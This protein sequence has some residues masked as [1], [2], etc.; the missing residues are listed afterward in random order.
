MKTIFKYNFTVKKQTNLLI[1]MNRI[2]IVLVLFCS[3]SMVGQE[4]PKQKIIPSMEVKI[5]FERDFPK[6]IPEWTKDFGGED[7]DQL[8]YNA[9]FKTSTSE[10]LAVYDNIGNLKAY[11]VLIQKKDIPVSI[12]N[13]LNKNYENLIIR[14]ASKVK[15]DNNEITY[16][17]GIV[18]DGK[19]YDTVFDKNGDFLKIIQ[20]E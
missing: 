2:A 4:K 9:K 11:E 6:E 15:N 12:V 17:V 14:E 13:Y 10:G 8:R 19:F 20:K 7:S 18:R 5:A 3:V 1:I 16:E